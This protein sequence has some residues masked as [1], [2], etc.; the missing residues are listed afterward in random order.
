MP[1]NRH[2]PLRVNPER[3]SKT[4][5]LFDFRY[6]PRFIL[7]A[8]ALS[9][10]P[11]KAAAW[12]AQGHEIVALMAMH[13]LSAPARSEVAH[14]LGGTEM[15]VHQSNWADEIRDQRRDTGPWHYVDIPLRASGYDAR[16][17]C[18]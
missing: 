16:R 6:L 10:T 9:S 11:Q 1:Y 3:F 7:L 13:D 12:G 4:L 17:D 8:A 15:M 14:L 5:S 18:P 2:F